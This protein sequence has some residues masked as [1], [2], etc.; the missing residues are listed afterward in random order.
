MEKLKEVHICIQGVFN[1]LQI[2]LGKGT[3]CTMHSLKATWT[4]EDNKA[5]QQG[6]A[7]S[8]IFQSQVR[9]TKGKLWT[10]HKL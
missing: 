6:L 2:L 5:I 1:L 10:K 9:D 4:P 7:A 8:Y 3:H